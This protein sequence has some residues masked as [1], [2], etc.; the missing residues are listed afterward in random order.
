M[1]STLTF[2]NSCAYDLATDYQRAILDSLHGSDQFET[3]LSIKQEWEINGHN[4]ENA[5]STVIGCSNDK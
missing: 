4:Y 2:E 5:L 1:K 3:M